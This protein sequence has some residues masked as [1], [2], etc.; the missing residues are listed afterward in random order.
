[1]AETEQAT[2]DQWAILELM[3][4]VR[5]GGRVTEVVLFGTAM[6]RIDV[7]TP[8]GDGF[9]TQF[10]GGGSVSR[11]TATSEE[12][13]RPVAAVNQSEPVHPWEMRQLA[14]AERNL[15]GNGYDGDDTPNDR[16]SAPPAKATDAGIP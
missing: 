16:Y 15:P 8:D 12:L 11:L 10:F 3:G 6:G 9:T 7:P 2:F 14:A 1:M 13:A 4:H 5:M